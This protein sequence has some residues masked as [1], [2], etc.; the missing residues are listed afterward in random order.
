MSVEGCTRDP[1]LFGDPVTGALLERKLE[2][3]LIAPLELSWWRFCD[4]AMAGQRFTLGWAINM[5][6]IASFISPTT[7]ITYGPPVGQ[8]VRFALLCQD[9]EEASAAGFKLKRLNH[10]EYELHRHAE[11][12]MAFAFDHGARR[13]SPV[14]LSR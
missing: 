2:F 3:R 8:Q 6:L 1:R 11:P 13:A 9:G 12:S 7:R 4:S 10:L 14:R 5:S